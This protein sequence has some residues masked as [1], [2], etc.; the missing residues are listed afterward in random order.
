VGSTSAVCSTCG[1]TAIRMLDG[2]ITHG[3]VDFQASTD[4]FRFRMDMRAR[5]WPAPVPTLVP[6]PPSPTVGCRLLQ[7]ADW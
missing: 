7:G 1:A 4:A 3:R 6:D 2:G 5:G